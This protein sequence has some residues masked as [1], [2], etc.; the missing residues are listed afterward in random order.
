MAPA[1][2]L[3]HYPGAWRSRFHHDLYR[4]IYQMAKAQQRVIV[5]RIRPR[6][7]ACTGMKY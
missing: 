4:V 5:I 2:E 6:P 3:R 7:I 1:V